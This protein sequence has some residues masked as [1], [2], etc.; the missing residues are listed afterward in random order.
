MWEGRMGWGGFHFIF[1]PLESYDGFTPPHLLQNSV[2]RRSSFY[3]TFLFF[4]LLHRLFVLFSNKK[5]NLLL[6]STVL[7][8]RVFNCNNLS[9]EKVTDT[10]YLIRYL[11]VIEINLLLWRIKLGNY[12]KEKILL[13]RKRHALLC[14]S[15]VLLLFK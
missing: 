7:L 12:L 14:R 1:S 10:K 6:L 11:F 3:F 2:L 15:P 8:L 13:L 9:L 4:F 5:F